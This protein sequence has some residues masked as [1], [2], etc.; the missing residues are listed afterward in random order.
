MF[1][2]AR[3]KIKFYAIYDTYNLLFLYLSHVKDYIYVYIYIYIY[4][5]A[6]IGSAI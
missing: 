1:C 6:K 2:K 5:L 3:N 4:I